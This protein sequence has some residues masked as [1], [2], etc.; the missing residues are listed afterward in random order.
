MGPRKIGC[1]R[2]AKEEIVSE[3]NGDKSRF[4][5]ERQRKILRRKRV[6][7]LRK[8]LG[9]GNKATRIPPAEAK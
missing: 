2:L 3:K 8:A 7:E 9:L 5:Q 4:D 1:V 6:R